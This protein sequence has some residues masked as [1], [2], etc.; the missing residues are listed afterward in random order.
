LSFCKSLR[1][2]LW[3]GGLAVALFVATLLT[4]NG[5]LARGDDD[6]AAPVFSRI[7]HDF[8]PFYAAG[9]LVREGRASE[10]YRV[11]PLLAREREIAERAHLP[12]GNGFGPF[13]NP[14]FYVLPFVPLSVLPFGAALAFW[15]AI[16]AIALTIAIVLLCRMLVRPD[17]PN[18]TRASRPCMRHPDCETYGLAAS[19]TSHGRDARV[20]SSPLVVRVDWRTWGLVPL[21]ALTSVPCLMA[22]THGQNTFCSLLLLTLAVVAWRGHRAVL[23]GVAVGLLAYKPQLAA[24]V[25]LIAFIDLGWRFAVAAAATVGSLLLAAALAMPGIL[26][27][28]RTSL[29][30]LLHFMQVEHVYMWERHVTLK[31]FWRL[32]VQSYATGEM[33]LAVNLLT[34][35]SAGAVV[36]SL[37]AAAV[38]CR[39]A[40]EG[41]SRDRLIAATVASMPLVMPFYFDY[42]LLL[43]AIPAV[44]Y[45]LERQS[46]GSAA[47]RRGV[48]QRSRGI[49]DRLVIPSFAALYLCL[50]VN[51]DV[52]EQTRV[53]LAVPLL[54]LLAGS[55]VARALR[56][57]GETA[58]WVDVE[59]DECPSPPLAA[60]A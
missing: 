55:L 43:L 19:H 12:I 27:A 4:A 31:A 26:D 15:L 29:P 58:Q 47:L 16:N 52:A 48:A 50:I 32:L 46:R 21:L 35:A 7:G 51:P 28:Y 54:A 23:A 9:S 3:A 45:A 1:T 60:A 41:I 40:V 14:P 57:G 20:T 53:N 44:L 37:L 34:V 11:E 36:V 17:M 6:R 18:V 42:D 2:R 39:S 5:V 33:N 56:R 25:G 38:R 49:P 8:L 30:Q 24:L 59:P 10:M 22:L 13:W